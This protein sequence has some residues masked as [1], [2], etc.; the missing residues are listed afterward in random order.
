MFNVPVNVVQPIIV[1]KAHSSIYINVAS[2]TTP[3]VTIPCQLESDAMMVQPLAEELQIEEIEVR[4]G[5]KLWNMMQS[6]LEDYRE[7]RTLPMPLS[8]T[9]N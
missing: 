6:A 7:G 9:E 5:S 1:E 3:F 2:D 4:E 8:D